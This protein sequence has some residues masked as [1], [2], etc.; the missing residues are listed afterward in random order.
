MRVCVPSVWCV[1]MMSSTNLGNCWELAI[2]EKCY[3]NG[4]H[5]YRHTHSGIQNTDTG[6][7]TNI[8]PSVCIQICMLP[9]DDERKKKARRKK[10]KRQQKCSQ[11]F[12]TSF[13]SCCG[14]G[15]GIVFGRWGSTQR[16]N[17][18]SSSIL[19]FPI[20][21]IISYLRPQ[22]YPFNPES[23]LI[24]TNQPP[25]HRAKITIPYFEFYLYINRVANLINIKLKFNPGTW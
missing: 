14:S 4:Q 9:A 20:L 6:S 18:H 24:I 23:Y 21:V 10:W 12:A 3:Q 22:P 1:F 2:L 19:Q 13:V 16:E 7:R 8:Y 15:G 5:R 11:A 25:Y 17:P